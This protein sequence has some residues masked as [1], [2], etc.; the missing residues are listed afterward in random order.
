M[1]STGGG[2]RRDAWQRA[3]V[4]A[5]DVVVIGGGVN[6]CATALQAAASGLSVALLEKDDFGSGTSAWN[7]RLIHGGLKYLEHADI[8]LVRESLRDREWLLHAAPHLVSPLRFLLPF[9][10]RNQHP[11]IVLRAGMVAYDVLS[12]DKTL[13]LHR[14]YDPQGALR[15]VPGLSTDGLQGGA[16]YS[17]GQIERAERLSVELALA[18][19]DAGALVLNHAR[20]EEITQ[21]GGRVRGVAAVDGLSGDTH[22]VTA[23]A[24]VNAAGPWVDRVLGRGEGARPLM[25]G[26]KGTHLVVDR[27]PGAPEGVAL[28][29]EALTDARPMMVIPWLGR[30]LIGA[31]DVRFEGELDTATNDADEIEYILRETNL[32]LPGADLALADVKW[33]WTGVRPLP[34]QPTGPTGDITRRHTVHRHGTDKDDP[35]DGLY[36]VIGGKLTTFRS[37]AIDVVALLLKDLG[38]RRAARRPLR[39][40]PG[41]RTADFTAFRHHYL[42]A[43]AAEPAVRERLIDL[44]G[45]RAVEV[46]SLARSRDLWHQVGSAPGLTAAEVVFAVERESA[47]TVGD[48]VARRVLTGLDDDQGR[49]DLDA[50]GEVLVRDAG[51][52]EEVVAE[53]TADYERYL[54]KFVPAAA[55]PQ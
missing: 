44:Y 26:T 12:Y 24:V 25:G 16:A 29:Y 9:Y 21:H 13:P 3:D 54:R 2:A 45:T 15:L 46:E 35:V 38:V 34:Y 31:T 32:V 36:S 5:F 37:L 1:S 19:Q 30:Y 49:A 51:W 43:S 4:T 23:R 50:I 39:R 42:G 28:Y 52:P 47:G 7:S 33:A 18:A 40:L 53:Q 41:A 22:R 10:K 17:D 8:R 6:G 55:V 48:V 11:A 20:V 14:V 27:F